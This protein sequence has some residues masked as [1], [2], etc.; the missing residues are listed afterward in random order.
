MV[1]M[2]PTPQHPKASTMKGR[3]GKTKIGSQSIN[4]FLS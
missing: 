2:P 4:Y 1:N 3:A